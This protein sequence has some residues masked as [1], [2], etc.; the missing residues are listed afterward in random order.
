VWL[1]IEFMAERPMRAFWLI[2]IIGG[3]ALL[4]LSLRPAVNVEQVKARQ[5]ARE[6]FCTMAPRE[7][8]AAVRGAWKIEQNT[9]GGRRISLQEY[10]AE[11]RAFLGC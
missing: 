6:K 3:G 11:I 9:P 5:Q 1:A 7:R 2:I 10:S 8:D 4:L